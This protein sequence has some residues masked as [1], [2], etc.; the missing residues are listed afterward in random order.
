MLVTEAARLLRQASDPVSTVSATSSVTKETTLATGRR[1]A[2]RGQ[3]YSMEEHTTMG[4]VLERFKKDALQAGASF[5]SE[6]DRLGISE[7]TKAVS[8]KT[9]SHT[10][11]QETEGMSLPG[12]SYEYSL[13]QIERVV[14]WYNKF[15]VSAKGQVYSLSVPRGKATGWPTS[16]S[17]SARESN[18]AVLVATAHAITEFKKRGGRSLQT[19]HDEL[20][21]AVGGGPITAYA[22]RI[23]H[24][25]RLVPFYGKDGAIIKSKVEP[26][27]RA[28]FISPKTAVLWNRQKV[29][30]IMNSFILPNPFHVNDKEAIQKI[31][32]DAHR[33]GWFVRAI[34]ASGFDR[35]HGGRRLAS[36]G[37][38]IS[39]LTS[40][41]VAADFLAEA[42]ISLWYPTNLGASIVDQTAPILPSGISWTTIANCIGS[43]TALLDVM[44]HLGYSESSFGQKWMALVWGDDVLVM[45][46]EDVSEERYK[47]AYERM[48]MIVSF[49]GVERF[50]GFVYD[51]GYSSYARYRIFQSVFPE[52]RTSPELYKLGAVARANLYTFPDK[53]AALAAYVRL[54]NDYATGLDAKKGLDLEILLQPLRTNQYVREGI[55]YANKVANDMSALDDILHRY[56]AV[57]NEDE[58]YALFGIGAEQGPWVN[59]STAQKELPADVK[60]EILTNPMRFLVDA[61][62]AGSASAMTNFLKEDRDDD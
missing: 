3:K 6:Y 31:I 25:K 18:N 2:K 28:I 50:L 29:K 35:M 21:A 47:N 52:R 4:V 49:E 34:D 41:T 14:A 60:N 9:L 30:E 62:G 12:S 33:K 10:S 11:W 58:V 23:S 54:N 61:S 39:R 59:L 22:E 36:I 15:S 44:G 27:A 24:A 55:A 57:V 45:T 46:D 16:V 20:S 19:F 56:S 17:G 32:N 48:K 1:I 43:T 8:L 5:F 53:R 38:V 40:D 51:K 7:T 37:A 26:R 42:G 13:A